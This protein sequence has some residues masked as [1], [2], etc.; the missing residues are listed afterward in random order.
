VAIQISIFGGNM[1]REELQCLLSDFGKAFFNSD[2][3][4]LRSCT[5]TDIEWHQHKGPL[6]TGKILSGV[7][8]ICE[9]ILR[10][11]SEWK[12]VL[13]EDFDN[14]FIDDLIVSCF[15][16]SGIDEYGKAFKAKA[17][18]L[19]HVKGGKISRKDSYW[20]NVNEE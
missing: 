20:K 13:Y 6:P 18:D 5:T 1:D 8:A 2:A 14:R 9:E 19:Y 10:R 4:K 17:V 7:E 15:L 12:E 11:K 16:V 3:T